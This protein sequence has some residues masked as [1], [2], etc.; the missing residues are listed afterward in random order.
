MPF[1]ALFRHYFVLRLGKSK[2]IAGGVS[3]RLR[4][5]AVHQYLELKLS[6]CWDEWRYNWYF[7]SEENPSPHLL[8][9]SFPAECL[10]NSK[11]MLPRFW[12]FLWPLNARPSFAVG[13]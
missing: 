4:R 13:S 1:V 2:W 11:E 12:L 6:S 10:A 5:S 7:I 8:L 9:P 3:F